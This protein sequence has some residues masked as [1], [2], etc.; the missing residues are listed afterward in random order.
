MEIKDSHR[1]AIK[2]DPV[3]LLLEPISSYSHVDELIEVDD[4]RGKHK[5]EY[6]IMVLAKW[7]RE[8]RWSHVTVKSAFVD[9]AVAEETHFEDPSYLHKYAAIGSAVALGTVVICLFI[10]IRR[11]TQ[12]PLLSIV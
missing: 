7:S 1:Y 2:M 4:L 12:K 9:R 3:P 10:F 8:T 6:Y 5:I 11:K